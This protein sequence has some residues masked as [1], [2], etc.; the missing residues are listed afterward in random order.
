MTRYSTACDEMQDA[1]IPPAALPGLGGT[2]LRYSVYRDLPLDN[3]VFYRWMVRPI[4][5][6]CPRLWGYYNSL[7]YGGDRNYIEG[8]YDVSSLIGG[9]DAIQVAFSVFDNCDSWYLNVGDCAEHTP[10]PYFD[11]IRLYRYST[12]GPQW[13]WR[14]WEI[15]QDTWP[16][17][18]PIES[19]CRADCANDLRAGD[20][21]VIA[22]G[23]SAVVN[24]AGPISELDSVLVGG[25]NQ[26]AVF[27]HVNVEY[28]GTGT[29]P[30]L[31]GPTIAGTYG[32]YY[33]DDGNWTILH[34]PTALTGAGNPAEDKYMI[35]LNDS[36]FTRGYLIEYYFK[37]YD[38]AGLSTTCP[39]TAELPGGDRFEFTC[40][41]TLMA[42]TLYVDDFDGRGTF[43]GM[44]ET[45]MD[46][47][48]RAV[49]PYPVDRYD[50]NTPSGGTSNGVGAYAHPEHVK[51]AYD[52]IIFD[53]GDLS[54]VTISEGTTHSDKSNDA[55]L[56]VE[57]LRNS[58]HRA[59]LLVMGNNVAEDLERS[60]AAVALELM[61]ALCGVAL[62][63]GSYFDLTGGAEGGGAA[64]PLISGMPGT[65]FDG[66]EYYAFGGCPQIDDFDV[67]EATGPGQ[68]CLQYADSGSTPYYA[69]IFTEQTNN[70]DYPM[71]TV[72]IGHSFMYIRDTGLD[73]LARNRLLDAVL[74]WFGNPTGSITGDD[75]PPAAA[76]L[77]RCWPNPFNPATTIA[78]TLR[79]KGPVTL[80]VYD[81]SGRLVRTLVEETRDAG[82]YEVVWDGKNGGGRG[83]ASG[84]YF[85]R[86]QTADFERSEKMVLLR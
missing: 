55:A 57:F 54:G 53:S 78:F 20:D 12:A 23:D 25:V 33:S 24:C 19:W 58:E 16:A 49:C 42:N 13:S 37:A 27:C 59:G 18:E 71:Q 79:E 85:C 84:I 64:N 73:I 9:F 61:S 31:F 14:G 47:T 56:L 22:P 52:V 70:Y 5:N 38:Q 81:V 26:A 35:D 66:L 6:G 46:P 4:V 83:V 3:L 34:C 2:V 51:Q 10:A 8:D 65:L 69:G 76:T 29:K 82:R 67:L 32:T 30:D 72:W 17:G 21:P 28:I 77:A 62:A 44:V 40:L 80:K 36:L 48:F 41:P 60:T 75:T 43:E 7:W 45:Y 86:M 50:V 63:D 68:Y 39:E 1:G 11:N 74:Q 15:F